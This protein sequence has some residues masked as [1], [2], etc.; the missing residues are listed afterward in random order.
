MKQYLV[1]L[2][3]LF[4]ISLSGFSQNRENRFQKIET[5]KIAFITKKLDL[6]PQEAQKFFP[7][8][9]EYRK[10]MR[11]IQHK[12]REDRKDFKQRKGLEFDSN[13]LNCKKKYRA[14]FTTA[15]S[16]TKASRFF[17]VEREFREQLFKELENRNK[18]KKR[19][20]SQ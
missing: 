3:L 18:K 14:Q 10:E 17:E 4:I 11:E 12:N 16:A 9:N 6:T 19:T 7:L 15:I 20:I 5:A 2:L 8:Y 13:V 1:T